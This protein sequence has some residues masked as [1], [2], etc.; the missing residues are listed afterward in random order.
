MDS[1]HRR[2]ASS[3]AMQA[4]VQAGN[5]SGRVFINALL[6][7]NDVE[8]IEHIRNHYSQ[9]FADANQASDDAEQAVAD[10][11]QAAAD[12]VQAYEGAKQA[13]PGNFIRRKRR[14]QAV[15]DAAQA[16]ADAAQAVA[17]AAQYIAAAEQA[18]GDADAWKFVADAEQA[19]RIN[20]ASR[21][22]R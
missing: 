7:S 4:A 2:A 11:A 20:E 3:D 1:I 18:E 19:Y 15:A 5:N 22:F 14:R 9:V 10:A 16:V 8:L 6:Y 13:L 12:A 21:D 17:D